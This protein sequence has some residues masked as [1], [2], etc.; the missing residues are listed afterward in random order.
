MNWRGVVPLYRTPSQSELLGRKRMFA[1]EILTFILL[2]TG[3][4]AM[5]MGFAADNKSPRSG[6]EIFN[7]SCSTCHAVNFPNAP[8]AHDTEAWKKKYAIAETQAK[9]QF[10]DLSG[11]ERDIKTMSILVSKVRN[12]NHAMPP[13]GLCNDCIDQEYQNAIEFMSSSKK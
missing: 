1:K 11:K 10:P 9:Q 5:Q 7:H 2:G 6:E 8:Q 3:L 4:L 13:K 12:G